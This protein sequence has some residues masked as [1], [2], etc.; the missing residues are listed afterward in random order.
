[1]PD[2]L[3]FDHLPHQGGMSHRCIEEGCGWPGFGVFVSEADRARHHRQHER[4]RQAEIERKREDNLRKARRLKRQANRENAKAYSESP[5]EGEHVHEE[6]AE[7]EETT[8]GNS[9]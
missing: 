1:V 2:K 5:T 3:G 4:K 7:E 9:A 8:T 6:E